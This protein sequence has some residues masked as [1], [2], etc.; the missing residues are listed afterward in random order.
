MSS[1]FLGICVGNSSTQLGTFVEGE[2]VE[3]ATVAN[4]DRIALGSNLDAAAAVLRGKPSVAAVLAT[5]KPHVSSWAGKEVLRR[6]HIKVSRV[7]DDLP[8]PIGRQ[9]D[10]EAIVGEDRLLTAAAAY[11]VLKQACVIVDAGTATTVD[12]VDGAGTYHGGAIGPGARLM[13]ES[14]HDGTAQLPKVTWQPPLEPIGHNTVEAIRSGVFHALRGMVRELAEHYAE[15]AGSYPVVVATGGD[16]ELL[17]KG[18]DLV[19]RIVPDL[20][21]LGIAAT[22]QASVE[23]ESKFG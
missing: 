14:L 17:F 23:G 11:S 13:L 4:N 18:F 19:E 6:L 21:L 9:L 5:V 8:I 7:E 16:A 2:L 20:A 10:P 12:F 22:V 15:V 3:S 1:N